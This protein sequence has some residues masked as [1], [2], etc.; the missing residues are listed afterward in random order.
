MSEEHKTACLILSRSF[1]SALQDN[2]EI[3]NTSDL[4]EFSFNFCI[5]SVIMSWTFH[6]DTQLKKR[7]VNV[8]FSNMDNILN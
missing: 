3:F 5:I 6:C 4:S 8:A 7:L 1:V 2:S